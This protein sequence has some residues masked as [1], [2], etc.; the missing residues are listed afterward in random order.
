M[1]YP[2][3]DAGRFGELEGGLAGVLPSSSLRAPWPLCP[4]GAQL[5]PN[6]NDSVSAPVIQAMATLANPRYCM[7]G[8]KLSD[9]LVTFSKI[10]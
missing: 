3:L 2:G 5:D 8:T 1:S 10:Y 9:I 6:G 4:G 7:G